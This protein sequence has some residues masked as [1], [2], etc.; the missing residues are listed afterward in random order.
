MDFLFYAFFVLIFIAV[1][2]A[3]EVSWQWLFSTQSAAARRALQR[4]NT[5]TSDGQKNGAHVSL[6]K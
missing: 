2:L 5:V 4:R 3:I 1:A 6:L